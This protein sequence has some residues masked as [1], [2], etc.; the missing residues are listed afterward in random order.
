M[1]RTRILLVTAGLLISLT[2]CGD[3]EA[4]SDTV[5]APTTEAAPTTAAAP[6][7]EAAPT[8][9]GALPGTD[10]G[11]F[12]AGEPVDLV[13]IADSSS[14]GEWYADLAAEALARE[15][16]LNENVPSDPQAIRGRFADTVAEAEIIVFYHH[17]GNFEQDMPAPT[18]E[19]GCVD[20]VDA[21][22]NPDYLEDPGYVGPEWTPG[23]EWEVV[24]AVP[25][26]EDWQ[27]YRDF[28]TGVWEAIWEARD[29]QPVVLRGYDVHNPWVGQWIEIGVEAE[30]TAIW[31][32]QARSA[33]EAAEAN[34][35]VFVSFYD[36]FNGPDHDE[37][38]RLKGWIDEDRFHASEAGAAAAAEALAA[39]G[40][41]LNDLPG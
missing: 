41:E 29:G 14:V 24:A 30:C 10:D 17:S 11:P 37:D 13:Y 8:T 18:F 7:T 28:L 19:R 6:T 16:R 35:A 22:E 34:G 27:P 39:V 9:A 23:T 3:S 33:R 32:G 5:A 31:E 1:M 40:F 36:L 26:T 38:A 25:S 4:G 15:V 2:S 20:P 21:L 12:P